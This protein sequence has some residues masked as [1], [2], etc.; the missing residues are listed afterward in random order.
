MGKPPEIFMFLSPAGLRRG[1]RMRYNKGGK[2]GGELTAQAL[3]RSAGGGLKRHPRR[4]Y[5]L[6]VSSCNRWRNSSS[7]LHSFA[8]SK[9]RRRSAVRASCTSSSP[10]FGVDM[11]TS[12]FVDAL[13]R[14]A[15]QA[16][17]GVCRGACCVCI[18]LNRTPDVKPST[19]HSALCTNCTVEDCAE[20]TVE[21]AAKMCYFI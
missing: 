10:V 15:G 9:S 20:C 14:F 3:D 6:L 7:V 19:V 17:G 4:F 16:V 8:S 18:V 1:G 21:D 12:P 5:C 2:R 13:R 11:F